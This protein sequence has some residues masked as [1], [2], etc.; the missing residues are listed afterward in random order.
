MNSKVSMQALAT[1]AETLQE[2]AAG[3]DVDPKK[4]EAEVARRASALARYHQAPEP[5]RLSSEDIVL[6]VGKRKTRKST[7][8]KALADRCHKSRQRVLV[9]DPH[10]EW[11]IHGAKSPEVILGPCTQRFDAWQVLSQ[12]RLLEDPRLFAAV[13]PASQAPEDWAKVFGKIVERSLEEGDLVL[14]L[15]EFGSWCEFVAKLMGAAA[16]NSRH[17][18]VPM[19]AVSQRAKRITINFRSQATHVNSGTQNED[20]DL[21]ALEE[22]AGKPFA[23]IVK[24][25]PRGEYAHWRDTPPEPQAGPHRRKRSP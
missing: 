3:V 5:Q 24:R 9:L 18:G 10:D 8:A 25:L 12:P 17:Y 22:L 4:R 19:V 7:R 13:V 16:L 2:W 1:E 14:F 20:D 6:F 23:G 21:T 15:E 11:S